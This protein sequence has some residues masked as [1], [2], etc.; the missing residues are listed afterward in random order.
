MASPEAIPRSQS[1]SLRLAA[2]VAA[3]VAAVLGAA[4]LAGW[5]FDIELVKTGLPGQA[6]MK[7]NTAALFLLAGVASRLLMS[8][9]AGRRLRRLA[10][11]LGALV[12]AVALLTLLE[13]LAGVDLGIDGLVFAEPLATLGNPHPGRMSMGSALA[14][15]LVGGAL[16]LYELQTA[17]VGR[18]AQLLAL[19]A[20][21]VPVQALVGYAYGVEPRSGV[22]SLTQVAFDSGLGHALLCASVLLARPESGFMRVFADPGLVG[23]MARRMIGGILLLPPALGWVF[24]VGGLRMGRYETILG[25]SFAVVSAMVIGGAV[26]WW[27]AVALGALEAERDRAERT[28]REQREWLRTTVSS[29]GDAVIAADIQGLVTLLNPAAEALTGWR[30][31]QATGRPLDEV[32]QVLDEDTRERIEEPLRRARAERAAVEL[33]PRVLL[34]ARGGEERPIGGS[35][36]PIQ[37]AH[38][39]TAGLVLAIQDMRER[40]RIERE[41]GTLLAMEQAARTEAEQASRAKDEFIA[42]VSHELRTP[43]NSVMGW[44]RLLR[45][46]RLDPASTARAVEAIERGASTQ[47]QIVDD[48]LDVSR[49]V[50]GRLR[51]DVRRVELAPVIEAAIDTV[52]PAAAAKGITVTAS[53]APGAGP[54]QGDAGRLQQVIW[55]LL[56]NA[57]KFTSTGRVEVRLEQVAAGVRIQVQDTGS[58]IPVEFLPHL[59]ERFRQAD[60]S[61]TR[62]H[63]GLG[64]GLAIVRHLVEAHGGTVSAESAGP[65]KGAT[66]TVLLPIPAPSGAGEDGSSDASGLKGGP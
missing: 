46:G 10:K 52:R 22:A 7:P 20:A 33:P 53:L 39:D 54:V 50:R 27:N 47:A 58:G 51:L 42:T 30:R 26:V 18:P 14:F 19:A 16:L 12:S 57:I 21:L 2:R 60:Q 31:E 36:A 43:L 17:R 1:A 62:A 4:V 41:R 6:A 55:N 28:E 24:L 44:A 64:I 56:S 35:V 8:A 37:D 15:L 48:L 23:S 29:I 63:G 38:G 65:G 40:R 32:F 59:F 13:Y 49:I 9:R 11:G 66:F 3:E 45:S 61:S 25:A 5:A 34:V